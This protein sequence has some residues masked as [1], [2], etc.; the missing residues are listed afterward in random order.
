MQVA[1]AAAQAWQAGT[2]LAKDTSLDTVSNAATKFAQLEDSSPPS[3]LQ[4][5]A[6][7]DMVKNL[8]TVDWEFGSK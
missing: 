7:E 2:D 6:W 1:A 4:A 5:P 8:E 3:K